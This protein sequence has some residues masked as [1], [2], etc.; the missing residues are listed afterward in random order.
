M[1]LSHGLGSLISQWERIIPRSQRG[2]TGDSHC[3]SQQA[4]PAGVSSL[5]DVTCHTSGR[6]QAEGLK[7]YIFFNIYIKL[8][9]FREGGGK[10]RERREREN[11]QF[12]FPPIG[13][14]IG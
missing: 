14:F 2:Q 10:E 4:N 9:D 8:I 6:K 1:I 13:A 3:V 12:V 7:I 11:Y 5:G